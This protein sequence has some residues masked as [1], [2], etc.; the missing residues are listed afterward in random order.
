MAST[1]LLTGN[2]YTANT[3]NAG[4]TGT[5]FT[6]V[7]GVSYTTPRMSGF[8]AKIAHNETDY[9]YATGQT[10]N[11]GAALSLNYDGGAFKAAAAT[12]NKAG[13]D[14][15]VGHSLTVYG[16]SYNFGA[17]TIMAATSK[18]AFQNSLAQYHDSTAIGLGVNYRFTPSFDANFSYGTLTND[19]VT[20]NKATLIGIVGRYSLS[21]RTSVYAGV[22]TVN[23][24]GTATQAAL[25]SYSSGATANSTTSASMLGIRHQF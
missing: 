6:Y 14:G 22:G 16:A 17:T 13:I 5:T 11:P 24:E 7:S 15:L 12:S 18:S 8:Q 9:S 2:Y 1:G 3:V 25:W 19:E 4:Q 23:N 10:I 20:A 21:K